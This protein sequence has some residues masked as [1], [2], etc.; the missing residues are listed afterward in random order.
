MIR[1]R[2]LKPSEIER[3]EARRYMIFERKPGNRHYKSIGGEEMTGREAVNY[4][5]RAIYNVEWEAICCQATGVKFDGGKAYQ[6]RDIRRG[7]FVEYRYK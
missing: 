2:Y 6:I 4:L 3:D 5:A 1:M 7:G